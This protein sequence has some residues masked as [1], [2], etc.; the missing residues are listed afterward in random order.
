MRNS[1]VI[2]QY[3]ARYGSPFVDGALTMTAALLTYQLGCVNQH[4]AARVAV[5]LGNMDCDKLLRAMDSRPNKE[6][7]W[8]LVHR[9]S[10][11]LGIPTLWLLGWTESHGTEIHDHAESQVGLTIL[12]GRIVENIYDLSG[13]RTNSRILNA[14]EAIAA[15]TPY[16]HE[17][18]GTAKSLELPDVSLHAYWP[19]LRTQTLFKPEGSTIV[20]SGCWHDDELEAQ[21]CETYKLLQGHS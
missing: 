7:A 14:R 13:K 4:D 11:A 2:P 12:R 18:H 21:Q 1:L 8:C 5:H 6:D 19:P 9:G 3:K 16:I 20:Q 17:V 15:G 10:L